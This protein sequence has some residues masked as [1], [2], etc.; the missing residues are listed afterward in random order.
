MAE[1]LS[2][3]PGAITT[4]EELENCIILGLPVWIGHL[5]EQLVTE[6]T[7]LK[8]VHNSR[9]VHINFDYSGRRL[10]EI[11]N[12]LP[13]SDYAKGYVER[14]FRTEEDAQLAV[15]QYKKDKA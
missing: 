12:G 6:R 13:M 1:E 9:G 2:H 5:S 7:P 3:P 14:I 15:H 8:I 4:R 11:L 10:D